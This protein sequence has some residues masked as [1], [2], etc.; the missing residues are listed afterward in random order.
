MWSVEGLKEHKATSHSCCTLQAINP[1][2]VEAGQKETIRAS[3]LLVIILDYSWQNFSCIVWTHTLTSRQALPH[4][5]PISHPCSSLS[6]TTCLS[7]YTVESVCHW[8]QWA[9]RKIDSLCIRNTTFIYQYTVLK[10]NIYWQFMKEFKKIWPATK[11]CMH[12][13]NLSVK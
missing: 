12:N 4:S 5:P 11:K 2:R 3:F 9:V 1:P 6:H 8:Q 13:L 10:A 7:I